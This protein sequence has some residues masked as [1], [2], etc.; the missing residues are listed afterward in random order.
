MAE[1][2]RGGSITKHLKGFHNKTFEGSTTK[3]MRGGEKTKH[4]K[5]RGTHTKHL[6]VHNETLE[7]GPL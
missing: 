4:L 3:H 6:G 2:L 1:Y 5:G 7:G